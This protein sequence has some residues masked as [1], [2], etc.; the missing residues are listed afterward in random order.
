MYKPSVEKP[1]T[2]PHVGKDRDG[3]DVV[4]FTTRH[5]TNGMYSQRRYVWHCI[6][7]RFTSS[8]SAWYHAD[9]RARVNFVPCSGV[10][11]GAELRIEEPVPD[12]FSEW[13]GEY[14][15]ET[16]VPSRH[17]Q[18]PEARLLGRA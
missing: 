16:L 11:P 13:E 7:L 18:S 5:R 3:N 17:G 1:E 10:I 4:W 15:F 9:R 8:G 14:R 12:Y 6:P 2:L